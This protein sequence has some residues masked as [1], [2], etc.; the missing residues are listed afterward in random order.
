MRVPCGGPTTAVH[1]PALPPTSHASHWP[2]HVDEQQTPSTH[3]PEPHCVPEVQTTPS[4]R[5]QVPT[6]FALQVAGA[7]QE[8][9]P[10]HVLSTQLPLV[11]LFAVLQVTPFASFATHPPALQ[12]KPEAHAVSLEHDVRQ[13]LVPHA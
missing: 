5:E 10:Q 3:L 6:P 7:T 1:V 4:P 9:L 13:A 2:V 12:K 8:L 11:Q